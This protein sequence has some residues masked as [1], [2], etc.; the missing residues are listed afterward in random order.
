MTYVM[1]IRALP[2]YVGKKSVSL[3]LLTQK[4]GVPKKSNVFI[5]RNNAEIITKLFQNNKLG[6][7]YSKCKKVR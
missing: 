3:T 5:M 7:Q 2:V 4:V 1:Y 6:F